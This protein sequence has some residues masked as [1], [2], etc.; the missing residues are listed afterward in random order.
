MIRGLHASANQGRARRSISFMPCFLPGRESTEHQCCLDGGLDSVRQPESTICC[1]PDGWDGD[2]EKPYGSR[3]YTDGTSTL[4]EQDTGMLSL[5][6]T[7]ETPENPRK[8]NEKPARCGAGQKRW[9]TYATHRPPPKKERRFTKSVKP[10][11]DR[12]ARLNFQLEP[13]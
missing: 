2:L 13:R 10:S 5:V 7:N 12:S 1:C 11:I 9:T 6:R 8:T 3:R 4:Q